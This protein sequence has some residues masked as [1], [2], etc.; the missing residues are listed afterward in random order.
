MRTIRWAAVTA[1]ALLLTACGTDTAPPEAEASAPPTTEVPS[2]ATVEQYA[3]HVASVRQSVQEWKGWWED[4]TCS[5]LAA[6]DAVDCRAYVVA[7][8][9][10][11]MAAGHSMSAI[12]KPDAPG[13]LGEPP[14][15]VAD[16]YESTLAHALAAKEA[17]EAY[18]ELD[19]PEDDDCLGATADVVFSLE[20]LDDE[21]AKW[22]PYL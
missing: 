15:E 1:A 7:G 2:T 21:F 20:W 5:T 14:A 16:L 4:A 3:G 17:G 11:G 6:Q 8:A 22:E 12:S 18:T 19:C 9:S 13:Y 10:T